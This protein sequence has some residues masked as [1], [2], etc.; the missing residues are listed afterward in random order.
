MQ[1][2]SN[3]KL[4]GELTLEVYDVKQGVFQRIFRQTKKN[5]I[6]NS[7]L[8]CVLD[9][10]GGSPTGTDYQQNPTWNWIWS[11]EVGTDGTAATASDTVLG[12][13]V[14]VSAFSPIEVERPVVKY[15]L[16]SLEISKTVPSGTATGSIITEA[17]IFTRGNNDDPVLANYR[18]MYSRIVHTAVTKTATMALVYN[19]RLGVLV[20]P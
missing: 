1:F 18:R 11:M 17:G 13:S 3:F 20:A 8:G 5:Q 4:F 9:L 19:W 16:W 6:T 10:L 14:W 2:Q 15:P 12:S 7:G